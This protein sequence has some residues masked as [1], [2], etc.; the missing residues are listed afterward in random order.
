MATSFRWF[1]KVTLRDLESGL[2]F[3]GG[4]NWTDKAEDALVYRD[5]E[6]ALEAA[7]M[8]SMARLELNALLFDDPRYTCR[9]ALDEC[10]PKAAASVGVN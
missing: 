8:S 2:Y 9:L 10:F 5:V 6:A 4:T 3:Q 1:M 7:Y